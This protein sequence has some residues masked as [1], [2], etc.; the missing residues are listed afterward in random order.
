MFIEEHSQT[1]LASINPYDMHMMSTKGSEQILCCWR[2][3]D[4]LAQH[5]RP[6]MSIVRI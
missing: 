6:N 4:K 3:T 1:C 5:E 2:A